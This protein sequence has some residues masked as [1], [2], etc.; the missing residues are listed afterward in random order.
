MI[1]S[2][3]V[4]DILN[5]GEEKASV[6][7]N[8][9]CLECLVFSAS[10]ATM[11]RETFNNRDESPC[12]YA[13]RTYYKVRSMD[14][15]PNENTYYHL[16]NMLGFVGDTVQAKIIRDDMV[17]QFSGKKSHRVDLCLAKHFKKHRQWNKLRDF[18]TLGA[19]NA[20]RRVFN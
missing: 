7:M 19:H 9:K 15:Q 10:K 5:A 8:A 18:V 11:S 17:A 14:I 1:V 6:K 16:V 2:D 13:L 4:D 12:E 20:V 3:V